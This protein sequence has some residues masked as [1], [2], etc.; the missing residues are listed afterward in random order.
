[1]GRA[2]IRIKVCGNRS[3]DDLTA[4]VAAGADAV[5]LISGVTHVSE[6]AIEPDRAAALARLVPPYVSVVLVT[7]L[8]TVESILALADRVRP[9]TLQPHGEIEPS[10]CA[11]VREA[12]PLL[13]TSQA[14][15][16]TGPEAVERAA[17]F[18]PHCD[19]LL[20]DSRTADRLGGTGRTHDWS[21]SRRIADRLGLPVILAGG[22]TAENVAQAIGVVEP[23][24]V[25][26]N[27]EVDDSNGDKDPQRL[28]AFTMAARRAE[29][30]AGAAPA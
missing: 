10:V 13:R 14:V 9:D 2:R 5:G 27:S 7:H 12:R 21:L 16:V 15:H 20:L 23:Y 11:A 28:R 25:D 30:P 29:P 26:V 17:R 1:V 18:A 24:A 3:E 4:A 22:L 8:A 6:D 19:A